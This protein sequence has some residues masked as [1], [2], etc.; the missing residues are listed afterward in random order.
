MVFGLQN[1]GIFFGFM[2]ILIFS[3]FA[4]DMFPEPDSSV[5]C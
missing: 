5:G 1:G 2:I 3:K 4:D